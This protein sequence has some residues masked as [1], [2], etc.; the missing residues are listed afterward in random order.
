MSWK[1]GSGSAE[2]GGRVLE[3]AVLGKASGSAGSS[4]ILLEH[5]L[6]LPSGR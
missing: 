2:I 1:W 6:V 5:G 3:G 4:S